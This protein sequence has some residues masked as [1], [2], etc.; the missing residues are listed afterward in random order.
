MH[1]FT[2]SPDGATPEAGLIL[3]A[4]NLYGTTYQGGASNYGTVFKLIKKSQGTV[5][6]S[7]SDRDG[8]YPAAALVRDSN[9]N[10]YGTTEGG[11]REAKY[12]HVINNGCGVIF[13]VSNTGKETVVHRFAGYPTEGS[14]PH[15]RSDQ[16]FCGQPL[17]HHI[18][19]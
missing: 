4:G 16:G 2:G 3:D 5:L 17:R 19:W 7:F 12:C 18:P 6:H 15:K 9:S 8:H 13:K 14:A 1:S 10:F 11:G